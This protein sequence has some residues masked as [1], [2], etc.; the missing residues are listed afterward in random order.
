MKQLRAIALLLPTCLHTAITNA[1]NE[2][3]WP[4]ELLEQLYDEVSD[5]PDGKAVWHGGTGIDE[6]TGK[7]VGLTIWSASGGSK[8]QIELIVS[9][10]EE[11]DYKLPQ[12]VAYIT[13]VNK[14]KTLVDVSYRY[15]SI[16][17]QSMKWVLIDEENGGLFAHVDG[18]AHVRNMMASNTL[19][20]STP[21]ANGGK[22]TYTFTLAGFTREFTKNC[23]WHPNYTDWVATPAASKAQDLDS[24]IR[25]FAKREY[26]VDKRMQNYVYEKQAAALRYLGTVADNES[27]KFAQREYP[28]DY[29]MQKFTYDKQTAAKRYIQS[30]DDEELKAFSAREYPQDFAMQKF[31]YDKQHSAKQY[32]SSAD[33]KAAKARAARDWPLDY[34]MQ[35]YTY[36]RLAF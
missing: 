8:A 35:K 3:T 28:E 21:Q 27:L 22:S 2:T 1:A 12:I 4:I 13:D 7:P 29:A 15:D 14:S 9:C 11:D 32:M 24:E 23:S 17:E 10:F 33:N 5:M 18:D 31:T 34:A 25:E 19:T 26:P 16:A 20:L 30:V 6:S 36:D